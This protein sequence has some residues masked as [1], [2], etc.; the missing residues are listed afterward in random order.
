MQHANVGANHVH[1]VACLGASLPRFSGFA[2][3]I[4]AAD[5]E[6]SVQARVDR[7]ALRQQA[8]SC[9]EPPRRC[10]LIA[11]EVDRANVRVDAQDIIDPDPYSKGGLL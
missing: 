11:R 1:A 2:R 4:E 5:S 10:P 6:I 3:E 9:K 7:E 8:F